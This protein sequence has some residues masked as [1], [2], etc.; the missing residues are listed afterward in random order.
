[1][2][3][4][5]NT[6]RKSCSKEAVFPVSTGQTLDGITHGRIIAVGRRIEKTKMLHHMFGERDTALIVA[7]FLGI[8]LE[9]KKVIDHP[10]CRST[11]AA[12]PLVNTLCCLCSGSLGSVL[13]STRRCPYSFE[14]RIADLN[15]V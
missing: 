9:L 1:M 2:K 11:E 7:E 3:A 12:A 14:N 8:V 5:R 10:R 13:Q 6:P 15:R 4:E